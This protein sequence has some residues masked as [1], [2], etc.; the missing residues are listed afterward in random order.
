[1]MNFLNLNH[2]LTLT[3]RGLRLGAS[4]R[5]RRNFFE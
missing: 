1:M 5:L 3:I 2:N 4:V